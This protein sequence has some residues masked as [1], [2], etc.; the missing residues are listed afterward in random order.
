MALYDMFEQHN[1]QFKKV[2][3]AMY[4]ADDK[5]TNEM[6]EVIFTYL[7]KHA[8]DFIGQD[9]VPNFLLIDLEELTFELSEKPKFGDDSRLLTRR[10]VFK[11]M[12]Y[13]PKYIVTCHLNRLID[14]SIPAYK[15]LVLDKLIDN[16]FTYVNSE[17][18][19][20]YVRVNFIRNTIEFVDTNE[21]TDHPNY[22]FRFID[23][24][25]KENFVNPEFL[26]HEALHTA[27]NLVESIH[28]QLVEHRYYSSN[29]NPLFNE[30]VDEAISK[31]ADA[32]QAVG[33]TDNEQ[34]KFILN[35]LR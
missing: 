11:E 20:N 32:Y 28:N 34:K 17:K 14:S 13:H 27:H 16:G 35:P 1:K 22:P 3:V 19:F 4:Q 25:F 33:N 18:G 12:N 26:R 15:Q 9:K 31:L 2:T 5:F 24:T 10:E 30:L 21:A 23:S 6:N 7:D 8:F 29:I